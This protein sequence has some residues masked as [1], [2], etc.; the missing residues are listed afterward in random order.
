VEIV[1]LPADRRQGPVAAPEDGRASEARTRP[2]SR[3]TQ[4]LEKAQ[5]AAFM[6]LRAVSSYA[7]M[8]A[9]LPVF[10]GQLSETVARLLR[11]RRAA[12][13]RLGPDRTLTLQPQPYGF[14]ADSPVHELR[15]RLP[16][17]GESIAERIVFRDELDLVG[18]TS[19]DLDAFWH[20][21]GLPGIRNSVAV[22]W[23]AGDRRIGALVA[24][25]S[26]RGFSNDDVWVLRVAAMA[27]GLMWQYTEAEQELRMTVERLEQA[28][29]AR[30]QLLGNIAAG[31]DEARRRF[32][33]ALHD[34]S[35]QLLTAAELQLERARTEIEPTKHA[36]QLDQLKVTLKTVEDSLRRLLL[37]VSPQPTDVPLGLD[38]AIRTRLAALRTHTGI[39]PDID[40]RLPGRLPETIGS[41]V[42]KNLSEA[43][44]NV[45]KHA[46]ATRINV[47]AHVAEGGIRVV[48]ADDGKGFVVAESMYVPG[49]LGLVAMRER[50]QLAG[51]RCHIESEPG[52]GA[53]VE[54]WVP[55]NQ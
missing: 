39:E 14:G 44:T 8:G 50:A 45:E 19:V 40:L 9:E 21:N 5:V 16:V 30:R 29:A 34:D 52:A 43:L 13:W 49:H 53:R 10:F 18:G 6:A 32:A 41:V 46:H 47:S 35:L 11:A 25:D 51:G 24:Y 22:S 23:R 2:A 36:A 15:F 4:R 27:T 7:E 33:N 55:I 1:A 42:F 12:F 31:G 37:N 3:A 17:D 54:F 28:A 48:V 20:A 38:E 26:R